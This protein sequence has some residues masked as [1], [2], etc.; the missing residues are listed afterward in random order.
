MSY[1]EQLAYSEWNKKRMEIW[2]R[3]GH[4][5]VGCGSK[6]NLV[7]HHKE[8]RSGIFA[9]E[10][11]NDCLVTLCKDCHSKEHKTEEMPKASTGMSIEGKVDVMQL[12]RDF[13]DYPEGM[14]K[15]WSDARQYQQYTFLRELG[16]YMEAK[17]FE[18]KHL[19][20]SGAV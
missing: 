20:E 9:W 2:Q 1:G 5:C 8:Y 3:D 11:P 14:E 12:A 7:V 16:E 17:Y 19:I 18:A 6:S 15:Y 4:K 10:Y 13:K